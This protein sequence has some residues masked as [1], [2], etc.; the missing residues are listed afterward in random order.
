MLGGFTTYSAFNYESFEWVQ[1]GAWLLGLVN[2]AAMVI[3]C[4]AAGTAGIVAARLLV[5][6]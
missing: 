3:S 6:H 5:G 4:L 2:I 1:D